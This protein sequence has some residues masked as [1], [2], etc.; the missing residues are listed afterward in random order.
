MDGRTAV[1]LVVT[2][3]LWGSAVVGIRATL[4]EYPPGAL[5]LARFVIASATL[6]ILAIPRKLRIPDRSDFPAIALVGLLGV[7]AYHILISYG[8]VSVEAG[9]ASMLVNTAPVFTAF[10]ATIF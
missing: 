3:L 2:L 1:A 9:A 4:R 5:A 8:L 10:L 7:T 6:S